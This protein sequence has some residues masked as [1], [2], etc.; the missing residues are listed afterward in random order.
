[1]RRRLL[2]RLEQ[3]ILGALAQHVD[4]VQQVDLFPARHRCKNDVLAQLAYII[5]AIVAGRVLLDEVHR[6]AFIEG[7]T[8]GAF[9]ARLP[10]VGPIAVRDLRQQPAESCFPSPTRPAEQVSVRKP[11]VR[12]D[13][14]AQS[15]GN[16]LLP[17]DFGEALGAPLPVKDLAH[18]G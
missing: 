8:R 14:V 12:R 10:L 4:L 16:S 11:A 9:V 3:R 7:E 6:T 5:D 15:A 1:M 18:Y 17:H 2:K 13:R